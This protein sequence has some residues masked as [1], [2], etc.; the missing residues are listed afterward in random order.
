MEDKI[1]QFY[2]DQEEPLKSALLALRDIILAQASG[3]KPAWKYGSP[4]FVYQDKNLCYLWYDKN[5]MHPYIGIIDGSKIDHP[6]LE[7]GERKMIKILPVNPAEDFPI[8]AI[9]E[10]LQEAMTWCAERGK[11]SD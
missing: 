2:L 11:T 1:A 9:E 3:I 7:A 6:I 8:E 5:T 4:F 10:V